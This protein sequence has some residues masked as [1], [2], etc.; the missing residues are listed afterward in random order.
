MESKRGLSGIITTLIII[1]LALVAVGIVWYVV[2]NVLETSKTE[3][4]TGTTNLFQDCVTDAGGTLTTEDG[5]CASGT[6]TIV[7][8]EYCCVP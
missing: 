1:A 2:S 6:K 7:G 4:E 3:V 5:T 8:G